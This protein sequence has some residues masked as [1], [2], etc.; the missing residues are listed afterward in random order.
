MKMNISTNYVSV[1]LTIMLLGFK[2]DGIDLSWSQVFI[3]V[4]VP[5]V[6]GAF[7]VCVLGLLSV[8]CFVL[9]RIVK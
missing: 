9:N 3:P 8:A 4:V 2:L 7:T 5:A 6:I 1:G